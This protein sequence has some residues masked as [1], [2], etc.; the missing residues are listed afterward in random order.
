MDSQYSASDEKN[1]YYKVSY[2]GRHALDISFTNL[3][4]YRGSIKRLSPLN[5]GGGAW[6]HS[7]PLYIGAGSIGS[8]NSLIIDRATNY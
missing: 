2:I 1:L 8:P 3:D 6:C 4:N 7:S 5:E